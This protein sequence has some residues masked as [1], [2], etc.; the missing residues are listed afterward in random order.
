MC[1]LSTVVAL[2]AFLSMPNAAEAANF[3]LSAR[4]IA[5]EFDP[6]AAGRVIF[7][8]DAEGNR[9]LI[10]RMEGITLDDDVFVLV[11]WQII[12]NLKLV[13][14]SGQLIVDTQDGDFIPAAN[15]GST[16]TI[17]T[18]SCW[19]VLEGNLKRMATQGANP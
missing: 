15:P 12:G 2:G 18:Q 14:G 9:Q 10:V 3:H 17:F 8:E 6:S 19:T 1:V 16:V 5:T 7:R 13:N 4:L 11:D